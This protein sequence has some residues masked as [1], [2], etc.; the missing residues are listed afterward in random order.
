MENNIKTQEMKPKP[1]E[2]FYYFLSEEY[3]Q[4]AQKDGTYACTRQAEEQL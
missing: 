1:A 2:P 4:G 3:N